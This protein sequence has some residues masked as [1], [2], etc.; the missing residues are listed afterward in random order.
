MGTR[1]KKPKK[2]VL[3]F[4]IFY[5]S[6]KFCQKNSSKR[7]SSTRI[8]MTHIFKSKDTKFF[9]FTKLSIKKMFFF[10]SSYTS[11]NQNQKLYINTFQKICCRLNMVEKPVKLKQLKVT[12][13]KFLTHSGNY[14]N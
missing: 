1:G 7:I 5:C 4:W 13:K 12:S 10:L 9:L 2:Q 8:Y 6:I 3:F 14:V 11:T